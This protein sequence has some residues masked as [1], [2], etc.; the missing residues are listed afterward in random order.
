MPPAS[1]GPTT[2]EHYLG[3]AFTFQNSHLNLDAFGSPHELLELFAKSGL[4]P[5]EAAHHLQTRIAARAVRKSPTAFTFHGGPHAA[6]VLR[7]LSLLD[8][9]DLAAAA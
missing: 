8:V 1:P 2:H 4:T 5:H 7:L 3:L 9:G 6:G